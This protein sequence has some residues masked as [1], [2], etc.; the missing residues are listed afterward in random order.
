MSNN[1]NRSKIVATMGP[2]TM[3]P[4]VLE[5]MILAGV[6]V[7]RINGSHGDY[8]AMGQIIKMVREI[9]VRINENII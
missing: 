3:D 9:N 5:K 1:Y 2:A 8:E 7:C 4:K 6:D